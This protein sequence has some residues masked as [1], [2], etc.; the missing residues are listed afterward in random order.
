MG[1]YANEAALRA[2]A[3]VEDVHLVVV[4]SQSGKGKHISHNNRGRPFDR[5]TIY[6]PGT[7]EKAFTL[8]T[9]RRICTPTFFTRKSGF[10]FSLLVEPRN[11]VCL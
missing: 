7:N 2:M 8:D 1:F 10:V 5:V 4:D 6:L 11:W 3:A 9:P